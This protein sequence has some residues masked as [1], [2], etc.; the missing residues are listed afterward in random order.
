M[1]QYGM[2]MDGEELGSTSGNTFRSLDPA[3]GEPWCEVA[4]GNARDVERAVRSAQNAFLEPSWRNMEAAD[5]RRLL[6]AIAR[7]IRENAADLAAVESRDAGKL[8][9]ECVL[10]VNASAEWFDYF[11]GMTDKI[12][13][14]TIPS[15]QGVLNYTSLEPY[16][17]IGAIVPG[18]SPFLLTTWKLAPALATG[19]VVVLKPSE[20]TSASIIALMRL[21][22]DILPKGV[23]NVVTGAGAETGGALVAHPDV[24]KVAFTGGAVGGA[25]VAVGAG[26]RVAPVILELGGKSANIVFDDAVYEKALAGAMAGVF[27][28][29]GQTCMAGSRLL[30]QRGIYDRFVGD[31]VERA[32]R[33]RVGHPADPETQVGPLGT[34][35]QLKRV[36]GLVADAAAAGA[37]VAV[38]GKR[39]VSPK[40]PGGWYFRPTVICG[41]TNDDR[42][43]R[44]EIFGP[45]MTVI[46]FEDEAEALRIANDSRFGLV[47]GLWTSNLFRAHR[48]ARA[49]NV[50]TVF[51]NLYRK[52][53]PQSPFGGWGESGYG[54]ENGFE[55]IREYTQVRSVLMD[56]DEERVQDPFVMRVGDAR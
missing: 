35:A 10:H 43:C 21:L 31:L 42:V 7:T 3:T 22:K 39:E 40:H 4:A 54:R 25:A 18:N 6:S 13:G 19:N 50:G 17:V 51:V 49:L 32:G 46:P 56:L 8:L 45:V 9:R 41:A 24:K 20:Y 38:G 26:K 29:T 12:C 34:E 23:I 5:R 55:V 2:W 27:A 47:A 1:E 36:E 11:A 48:M 14:E 30:V 53:A 33:I 15:D 37:R 16:G 52:V 28:A 44:E